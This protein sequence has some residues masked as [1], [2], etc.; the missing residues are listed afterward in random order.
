LLP[1]I[2]RAHRMRL[3]SVPVALALAA[4]AGAPAR[5]LA[6]PAPPRARPALPPPRWEAVVLPTMDLDGDGPRPLR[7]GEEPGGALL[8]TQGSFRVRVRG[9][10]VEWARDAPLQRIVANAHDGERWYFASADGALFRADGF[11]GPLVRVG[12]TAGIALEEGFVSAG[13]LAVPTA[14]RRLW[15]GGPGDTFAP[16]RPPAD[17][18]LVDTGFVDRSFGVVVVAPGV[19]LRTTDGGA[20][21]E[22]VDT[23]G[24]ATYLVDP[25]SDGFVLATTGGR[26]RVGPT[27]PALPFAGAMAHPDFAVP[28]EVVRTVAASA[29]TDH[30]LA[31][32]SLLAS[33]A[34]EALPDGR[35]ARAEEGDAVVR[36]REGVVAR[37]ELPA[38]ACRLYAWGAQIL[39]QCLA[40][41]ER[42]TVL[43]ASDGQRPWT[44][45]R[46]HAGDEPVLPAMD[47]GG[48]VLQRPCEGEGD[49]ERDARVVC[50]YDGATWRTHALPPDAQPLAAHGDAL[51]LQRVGFE[52]EGA[53][54]LVRA[55]DT[56][57]TRANGVEEGRAVELELASA[58]L[59]TATFTT[60]GHLAGL[61]RK[62]RQRF[63]ALGIPG[64]PLALRPLPAGAAHVAFAS[65]THGIAAG[66]HLGQVWITTDGARTWTP[67]A[68]PLDGDASAV[69]L[70]VRARP[71]RETPPVQA[72]CSASACVVGSRL[73][74]AMVQPGAPPSG[75]LRV[76]A[77]RHA[78]A[79]VT[80]EPLPFVPDEAGFRAGGWTCS[81]DERQ[82][83][84]ALPATRAYGADG[85]LDTSEG[86]NGRV[87]LAWGG[88]DEQGRFR[89]SARA[90][91]LPEFE[92][93]PGTSPGEPVLVPRLLTRT[94]AVIERCASAQRGLRCGDVV[95]ALRNGLPRVLGAHRALLDVEDA[96]GAQPDVGPYPALAGALPLPDGGAVLHL[97][98][99]WLDDSLVG[100][101]TRAV[102]PVYLQTDVLLRLDARGALAARRGYSWGGL[103]AVRMLARAPEGPGL[104]VATAPD[105]LALAFHPMDPAQPPRALTTLPRG[106]LAPCD[107]PPRG[108]PGA[109][110]VA[111]SAPGYGPV[112]YQG[113][114]ELAA[115]FSARALV[116]VRAGGAVCQRGVS[117][118]SID[119]RESNERELLGNVGGALRLRAAQGRI[120][121]VGV[122]AARDAVLECVPHE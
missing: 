35:V 59:V 121:A 7:V 104:A 58:V 86:A 56:E 74:W 73:V 18:P 33:P 5:P 119:P 87:L 91:A 8:L 53:F 6:R 66:E 96:P 12:E 98:A 52:E 15:L 45:L 94:M 92:P 13:M 1:V 36:G 40:P 38:P 117:F 69:S 76:L 67:L 71:F 21:Y 100:R 14:A 26:L 17:G 101:W 55:G 42:T 75:A 10:A 111:V 99:Q 49:D 50:W 22:R 106:T 78:P 64:Q 105:P 102:L 48:L 113:R 31:Y 30:P 77:A 34:A 85:W 25:V 37:L 65:G 120:Q 4:C 29:E 16:A 108:E 41:D 2:H 20:R 122:D 32:P 27:G 114:F 51:L 44:E 115:P 60:D 57:A 109:T 54:R 3:A 95:V 89:A 19:L 70:D 118:W 39:A 110:V 62:G 83:A 46:Q 93:P 28:P 116:E 47:G 24:H 43:Y 72:W 23:F 9:N 84:P 90:G 112:V 11:L 97:R 88:T 68:V 80:A 63:A 81:R 103:R 107:G 61:A 79:P 82:P